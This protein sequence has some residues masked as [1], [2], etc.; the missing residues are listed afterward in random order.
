MT[1][2][3]AKEKWCP[4]ARAGIY[5]GNGA[6]AVNRHTMAVSDSDTRC[7]GSGCM[8]WQ[9]RMV[10]RK[11][12]PADPPAMIE[13]VDVPPFADGHCGLLRQVW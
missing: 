4:F 10:T 12:V 6:V 13:M 7:I 2:D 1:E 3:E 11:A 5:A 8:M 9:Q